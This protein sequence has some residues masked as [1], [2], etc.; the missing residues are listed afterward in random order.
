MIVLQVVVGILLA[1]VLL[2]LGREWLD[3]A[4]ASEVERAVALGLM[5]AAVIGIGFCLA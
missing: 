2:G 1:L 5:I 4:F 3:A